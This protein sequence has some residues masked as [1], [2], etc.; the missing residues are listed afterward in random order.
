MDRKKSLMMIGVTMAIAVGTAVAFTG[1]NRADRAAPNQTAE[2]QPTDRLE[3]LPST[4]QDPAK[5]ADCPISETQ[6]ID[7]W[8]A[9]NDDFGYQQMALS[10]EDG[11]RIFRT[12]MHER[13]EIVDGT[14]SLEKCTLTLNSESAAVKNLRFDVSMRN[15]DTLILVARAGST[16]AP[17]GPALYQRVK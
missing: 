17:D 14:W 10:I 5:A 16:D 7:G 4:E 12:W 6:I 11:Q 13:P 1:Y 9:V 2:A 15:A 3:I 8:K